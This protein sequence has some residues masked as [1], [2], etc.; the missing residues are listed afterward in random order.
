MTYFKEDCS[1]PLEEVFWNSLTLR[2]RGI[3]ALQPSGTA[4]VVTHRSI[5]EDPNSKHWPEQSI[6]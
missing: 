2:V 3:T 1:I 5:S 4:K 6:L